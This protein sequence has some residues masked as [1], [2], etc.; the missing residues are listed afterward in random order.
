M[1]SESLAVSVGVDVA[2]GAETVSVGVG[3]VVCVAVGV[4]VAVSVGTVVLVCVTVGTIVSVAVAVGAGAGCAV[5]SDVG[6]TADVWVACPCA[7][8]PARTQ[9]IKIIQTL[10]RRVIAAVMQAGIP[11]ALNLV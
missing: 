6:T 10:R 1:I 8:H 9:S 5:T 4:V 3:W 2:V 7:S 11:Y